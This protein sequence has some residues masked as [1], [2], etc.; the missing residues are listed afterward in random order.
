MLF[1]ILIGLC[2]LVAIPYTAYLVGY[3][4]FQPFDCPAEKRFEDASVSVVLPTYNEENIVR[5]KLKSLTSLDYP[6][7]ALEI[8]VVDSSSDHTPE[9]VTEFVTGETEV[10]V[11]L[12]E[13]SGRHGVATAVNKGVSSSCGEIVFRTDCD[14]R[15]GERTLRHAV[16]S[17]RDPTVGA[18]MGRQTTVLGGSQVE[19]DYR[20]IQTRNQMLESYVDSTFIVHGPCFAF[21]RSDFEPIRSD[22]LADD[23]EIGVTL[24]RKGLRVVLDP[25]MTFTESGVS[26]VRGRRQR[27]DRRAMG[28]IQLLFRSRD[29]LGRYGRYGTLILP[30]NWWLI[31]FAPWLTALIAV[32]TIVAAFTTSGLAGIS[33]LSM[34]AVFVWLGQRDSLGLV[35]PLYA[36][37]DSNVSLCIATLRL[38]SRDEQDGTWDIDADSRNVFEDE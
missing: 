36:V 12:V 15:I 7:E 20:N 16:A 9:I 22:S 4:L 32:V 26:D 5:S 1:W 21:R 38:L 23:T 25:D 24:R 2:V 29:M 6:A 17:L 19:T 13:E 31:V 37:F 34:L 3:V 27:K 35:Q 33:T 28:L 8:I 18:V 14:S 30:L 10:N 11:K